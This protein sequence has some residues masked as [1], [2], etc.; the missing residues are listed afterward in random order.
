MGI[1]DII[2][3]VKKH[4]NLENPDCTNYCDLDSNKKKV[5]K[6]VKK[7]KQCKKQPNDGNGTCQNSNDN[8]AKPPCKFKKLKD[9]K[10]VLE[11]DCMHYP[12]NAYPYFTMKCQKRKG[13]LS[14]DWPIRNSR[15]DNNTTLYKNIFMR[16]I[17]EQSILF[18]KNDI[19]RLKKILNPK[20]YDFFTPRISEFIFDTGTKGRL[21]KI[22][23]INIGQKI[24]DRIGELNKTLYNGSDKSLK[25]NMHHLRPSWAHGEDTLD[26]IWPSLS[27][28]QKVRNKTELKNDSAIG[29]RYN[30]VS[31]HDWWNV[32]LQDA[33][34]IFFKKGNEEYRRYLKQEC[35]PP[36]NNSTGKDKKM[37]KL[38]PKSGSNPKS[39]DKPKIFNDE[40]PVHTYSES[41]IPIIKKYM[42][43]LSP[44]IKVVVQIN[45]KNACI[46]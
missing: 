45:C 13:G 38:K 11:M 4:I 10:L 30:V 7:S 25:I 46:N 44:P 12:T 28:H 22:I 8:T 41:R 29:R 1:T 27:R 37:K 20:G 21:Y 15:P 26:N 17:N 23:G 19:D 40:N 9:D 31:I 43:A 36:K 2:D 16:R 39:A 34:E 14:Y 33:F 3:E 35:I 32:K 24:V 5:N 42:Q 18:S 6:S